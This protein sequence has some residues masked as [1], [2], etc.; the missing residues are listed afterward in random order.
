MGKKREDRGNRDKALEDQEYNLDGDFRSPLVSVQDLSCANLKSVLLHSRYIQVLLSLTL[1]GFFLRFYHLDYNSL[2]L[3]EATTFYESQAS[4]SGIWQTSLTGEFHPPLFNWIIHIMLTFGQSEIILRLVPAF[5]GVL[6]IPTFYL[7]GKEYRD[8][9]VGIISAALLTFSY[10]GIFYSQEARSY[11]MMLF[12]FS[13]V[14]LF[15]LRALRTNVQSDWVL[16]GVFSA[17]S[18]WTHYYTL[19]GLAILF[20]HAVFSLSNQWKKD[21]RNV[22]NT[23]IGASLL[24]ICI[25]PLVFLVFERYAKL[26]SSPPTYGVLGPVLILETLIRF[27]GGYSPDAWLLAALY[28][29]LMVAGLIFLYSE[30]KDKCLFSGMMLSIPLVISIILSSKITMN[31]RY[32]IYLLP[33]FLTTIAMSYPLLFKLIPDRKMLYAIVILI[34]IINAPL[35][36]GYYS[37]F[38]KEDWRGLAGALPS[39]THDGD[40]VVVLPGYVLQ[41]FTYYYSNTTD[42]TIESG[43]YTGKELD[44]IYRMKGNNSMFLVVTGDIAAANPNGDAIAWIKEHTQLMSQDAG[45]YLFIAP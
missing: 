15:Y 14:V 25:L 38:V 18:V 30:N 36:V 33:I 3:D 40:L 39:K 41:P 13:L 4:F 16:F 21:I 8:K 37:G 2:W 5:L 19:I 35:L 10:F 42:N 43:A 29:V 45:I 11:S 27:S 17:L 26:S 44:E 9:N 6:T 1:L 12:F 22:K 31:P 28:F 20:L 34:G 23:V 24:F 32:L 7:I